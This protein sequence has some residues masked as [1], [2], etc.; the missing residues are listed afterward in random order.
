MRKVTWVLAVFVASTLLA[1]PGYSRPQQEPP[2]EKSKEE[3]MKDCP[4]HAQHMAGSTSVMS[5]DPHRHGSGGT[6][7]SRGNS[8]MGFEQSKT[9]H[10]F[11]LTANGGIIQVQANDPQDS[12]SLEQIRK[13]FHHIAAA[14]AS[15]DFQIPMLVHDAIP[16]GTTTMKRLH[17]KIQYTCEETPAGARV[18]IK[19][20]DPSAMDAIH[21]FLRYQIRE[22]Q[23]GDPETIG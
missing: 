13:H 10:H 19:T 6:L 4:M 22:H 9:T 15:G 23:T 2:K 3:G 8:A 1:G 20:A 18:L 7:E 14:F 11:L 17:E 16:P 5:D 21:D 12:V